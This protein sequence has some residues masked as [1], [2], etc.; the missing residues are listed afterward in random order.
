MNIE[1]KCMDAKGGVGERL[2]D[3]DQY[4]H[5]VVY[6]IDNQN[7]ML[8]NILCNKIWICINR[9]VWGTSRVLGGSCWNL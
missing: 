3:W 9:S 1:N 8:F 6:K 5:A 4:I 7:Y 2:G